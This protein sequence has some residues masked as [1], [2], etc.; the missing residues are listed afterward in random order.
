MAKKRM[1]SLDVI[2]T[3]MFIEMPIS[4]RLLYYELGMRADDDGFVNNWKKIMAFT[5][6]KQDDLKILIT[7]KYVIPFDSGVIVIRH[8]RM[9]NYLQNDRKKG[10]IYKEELNNLYLDDNNVYNLDTECIHSIEESSVVENSIEESSVAVKDRQEYQTSS[11]QSTDEIMNR[12]EY[13]TSNS[14]EI[15]IELFKYLETNFGRTISPI[16]ILKIQ[17]YKDNFSAEIIKEAID[18][19]CLNNVKT[20]GYVMGILNS[21]E[22]KGFKTL[23]QCRQE[24]SKN[25]KKK[26]VIDPEWMDEKIKKQE[27]SNDEKQEIKELL[28]EFDR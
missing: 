10:T 15:D 27:A 8:W 12:Q 18:K 6:L 1:F 22:S 20:I 19:A 25:P 2:D 23:E 17:S 21:W 16:E 26:D 11:A 4:S 9:N 14:Q 5:G 28:Q 24:F 13:Q 7:K 3:D